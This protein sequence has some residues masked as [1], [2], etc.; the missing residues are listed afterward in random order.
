M[1]FPAHSVLVF[2]CRDAM[3]GM[4]AVRYFPVKTTVVLFLKCNKC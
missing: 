4:F 3:T 2:F 1:T